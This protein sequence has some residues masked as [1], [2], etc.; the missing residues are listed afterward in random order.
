MQRCYDVLCRDRE[1]RRSDG[2]KITLAWCLACLM[3]GVI[4]TLVSCVYY[5]F[6]I[7]WLENDA[8]YYGVLAGS[9]VLLVLPALCGINTLA[10]R[11]R[12]GEECYISCI[13]TAYKNLPR[14]WF[15]MLIN[16]LPTLFGAAVVYGA[17]RMWRETMQFAAVQRHV[18]LRLGLALAIIA[19][20]AI[21]G[22]L[23]IRLALRF[24]L[25]SAYAFRGDMSL[26]TA[27][28]RSFGAATGRMRRMVR[29]LMK[30]IGWLM[31]DCLTLGVLFLLHTAPR[32]KLDY[33]KF[34]DTLPEREQDHE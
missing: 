20:T 23:V 17:V 15:V 14:T 1:K 4:L 11:L 29:F 33:I 3:A 27:L 6:N 7:T 18:L 22:W 5:V 24:M 10:Y 2:F 31:L 13:F 12:R 28:G 32:F 34:A 25:F 30:Y 9:I 8:N 21:L 16:M 26:W 19:A